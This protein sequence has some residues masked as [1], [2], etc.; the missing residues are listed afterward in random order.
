[1]SE[2]EPTSFLFVTQYF[3]PERGAAQVRLGAVTRVLERLGHR[4]ARRQPRR[5]LTGSPAER[6]ADLCQ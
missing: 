1:M 5:M 4:V 6:N 3:P 2:R